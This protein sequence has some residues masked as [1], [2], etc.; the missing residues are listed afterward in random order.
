MVSSSERR[1]YKEY[2][3]IM[4]SMHSANRNLI[5]TRY[6]RVSIRVS[7]YVGCNKTERQHVSICKML[8]GD[9]V[10]ARY[11]SRIEDNN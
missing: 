4:L 2:Y 11:E 8:F 5:S 9:V 3:S 10:G 7:K 1:R 6:N